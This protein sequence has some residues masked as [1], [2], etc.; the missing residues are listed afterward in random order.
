MC[1][2]LTHWPTMGGSL[3]DVVDNK[4]SVVK[5]LEGFNVQLKNDMNQLL[6]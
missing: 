4:V 5:L 2:F 6:N 3:G 1:I